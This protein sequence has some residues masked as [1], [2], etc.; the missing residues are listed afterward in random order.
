MSGDLACSF[1]GKDT[2]NVTAIQRLVWPSWIS[3]HSKKEQH[4]FKPLQEHLCNSGHIK[5]SRFGSKLKKSLSQS[6]DWYAH[7]GI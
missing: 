4:F 6:E 1:S 7:V 3:N 5:W 2:K